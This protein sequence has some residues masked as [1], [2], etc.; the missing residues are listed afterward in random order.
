MEFAFFGLGGPLCRASG[1][2]LQVL[3]V[4]AENFVAALL[5]FVLL[6]EAGLPSVVVA[7]HYPDIAAVQAE[8]VVD[9][10][11]QKGAVMADQ[12][13]PVL[14]AEVICHQRAAMGIEVIGGLVNE[15]I[16]ILPGEQC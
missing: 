5:V 6:V 12:Q 16:D 9:A 11:V 4:L 13:V 1:G 3:D 14:A 2:F 10:A 15:G 8:H 7:L